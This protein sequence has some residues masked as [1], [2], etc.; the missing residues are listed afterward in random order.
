MSHNRLFFSSLKLSGN[1]TS[2][3]TIKSPLFSGVLENG[4]PCYSEFEQKK[5][6]NY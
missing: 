1:S 2:N 4:K 6:K 5:E 3:A